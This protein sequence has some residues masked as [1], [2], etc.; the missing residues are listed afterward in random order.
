MPNKRKN[1][2]FARNSEFAQAKQS[3]EELSQRILMAIIE[4][5]HN[6]RQSLHL[7]TAVRPGTFTFKV[8]RN[9]QL[10]ATEQAW[11]KVCN[12]IDKFRL[13]RE[14]EHILQAHNDEGENLDLDPDIPIP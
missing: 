6:N 11:K 9:L 12:I 1:T 4:E 5:C 2:G 13:R 14:I 3:D 10:A 8:L 7:R